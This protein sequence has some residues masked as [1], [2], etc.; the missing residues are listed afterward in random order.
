MHSYTRTPISDP[1]RPFATT[2]DTRQKSSVIPTME[3]DTNKL[4]LVS[5]HV[6]ATVVLI[7]IIPATV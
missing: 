2:M 4:E 1:H 3:T 6:D 7:E 5:I